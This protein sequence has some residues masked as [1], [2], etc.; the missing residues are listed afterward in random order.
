MEERRERKERRGR[1]ADARR[2]ERAARYVVVNLFLF[3]KSYS[4]RLSA[5]VVIITYVDLHR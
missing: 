1:K 5:T 4:L 2:R 3:N